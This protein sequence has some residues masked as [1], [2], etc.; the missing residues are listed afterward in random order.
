[1]L[2]R[3]PTCL[4]TCLHCDH[5][6]LTERYHTSSGKLEF[7]GCWKHDVRLPI[8]REECESFEESTE[9]ITR[10]FWEKWNWKVYVDGDLVTQKELGEPE[11]VDEKEPCEKPDDLSYKKKDD[12][13]IDYRDLPTIKKKDITTR[14]LVLQAL[15]NNISRLKDIAQFAGMDS[16]T[17]HYHVRNLIQEERVMKI[18]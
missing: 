6:V 3:I 2:N 12:H 17:V 8:S 10:E 1:V 5:A 15:T 18:S 9:R 11:G 14:A 4:H 13:I 16:S 7:D